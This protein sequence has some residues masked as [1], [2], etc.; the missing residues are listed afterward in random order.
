MKKEEKSE[1]LEEPTQTRHP[2]KRKERDNQLQPSI[3]HKGMIQETRN[4]EEL[5]TEE[6]YLHGEEDQ[7][8]AQS[9]IHEKV[10]VA[11][12]LPKYLT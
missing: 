1:Y 2:S 9:R 7:G 10:P 12:R 11:S 5:N 3:V 8:V 4:N 6:M